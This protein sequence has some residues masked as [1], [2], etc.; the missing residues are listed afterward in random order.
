MSTVAAAPTVVKSAPELV[1][2][3]G[4]TPGGTLPLSSIDKTA[5][6]RVSVDFIQVFPPAVGAGGDQDTAV[7]AMRDGF[8]K[9]L[10]PYYPVAGRIADASPG[11]PVVE[12]T[13]QG[14]W[15]V[16][17]AASCALADVNY[18]ERPLLIPK[19]ELLPRPPPEEK[20]EDLVLMAQVRS[21]TSRSPCLIRQLARSHTLDS[22]IRVEN[23]FG[24]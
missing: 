2:P 1:A 14:V 3:V 22:R 7:A 20:L 23:V 19:E 17:A 12:C 24:C 18:L 8:A 16:E 4:P 6:V 21:L 13:G 11:E 10:V 15:F 5:A 9:A